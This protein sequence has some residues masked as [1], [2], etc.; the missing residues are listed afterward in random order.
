MPNSIHNILKQYWGYDSFR[1]KQE[2]IINSVLQKKD[3][4]A[5]LPT[6]GGKSICYQIPGMATDGITIVI[7][8]LIALMKD[9][10][11]AL[12][13]RNI[14]SIA[15]TSE[16]NEKETD[17]AL[18]D[19]VYGA[20]KFLYISPE[21]LKNEIVQTR[22]SLMNV[23]LI[24]VDEAHCISQWGHDFRPSYLEIASIRNIIPNTPILALTATATNLVLKDIYKY[25]EL[26]KFETFQTSFKRD[27]LS[28]WVLEEEDKQYRLLSVLNKNVGT[29]IVYVRNRRKTKEI[30]DMLNSHN[31]SAT[32]YHAGID[33][34]EKTQRQHKWMNNEVRVIVSTNAFGMGIDK[35]DVRTVIHLDLPDSPEAY[36]Q[37]AGR[38]GRDGKKAFAIMIFNQSDVD[39]LQLF[40]LGNLADRYIVSNVLG[41]LY[42]NYRI[43]NNTEDNNLYDFNLSEFVY[44]NN[45]HFTKT[46]NAIKILVKE[47]VILISN[48]SSVFSQVK[49]IVSNDYLFDYKEKIEYLG[50]FATSL[51]RSY[52]GINEDYVK[53]NEYNFALRNKLS[54][55]QVRS[56]LL[57]L[58]KDGI[59]KYIP[60][61]KGQQI[62]FLVPR[63]EKYTIGRISKSIEIRNEVIENR[64]KS[65]INYSR[66]NK[67]CRNHQ[68]L[69]YFD[70]E[71]GE[72]CGICDV[73]ISK[74]TTSANSTTIEKKII[75]IL[76]KENLS[77]RE[78]SLKLNYSDSKILKVITYLLEN[79]KIKITK[80]NKYRLLK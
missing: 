26:K 77:S 70:Q 80:S 7:S 41:H 27:N 40:H 54:Q 75:S 58:Q 15:L 34:I 39:N 17:I 23:S 68:M 53:I 24:A 4:I 59:I 5:L 9:Q 47:D 52:G 13:S 45:L 55:Q 12:N 64:I 36:F 2:D 16:L 65:M 21:K 1:P 30:S 79:S 42:K 44:K 62:K 31:I 46:Y 43:A 74:K 51:L 48:S 22:I 73:C 29:A 76:E 72:E 71:I 57:R 6:G 19:C 35:P 33:K 8:P 67:V 25:L 78:I 20:I 66:N 49:F 63:N 38:A 10:I 28:F 60:S 69:E 3:T 37:E 50:I 11:E 61:K 56:N 32:F 14:S 18:D